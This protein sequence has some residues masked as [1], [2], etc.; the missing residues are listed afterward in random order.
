MHFDSMRSHVEPGI[1]GRSRQG[2]QKEPRAR[3]IGSRRGQEESSRSR[4]RPGRAMESPGGR[5]SQEE[6]GRIQEGWTVMI[7]HDRTNKIMAKS[8][9]RGWIRAGGMDCVPWL[10]P[11]SSLAH[12][13]SSWPLPKLTLDSP[14]FLLAPCGSF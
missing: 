8:Y 1:A 6:P 4:E 9:F 10:L 2:V 3:S 7:L 11:V 5:P 13:G 14:R 12:P